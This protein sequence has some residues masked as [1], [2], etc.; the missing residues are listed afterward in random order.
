M[1]MQIKRK[2]I[3]VIYDLE[4]FRCCQ[5]LNRYSAGLELSGKFEPYKEKTHS[6]LNGD[7]YS[8]TRGLLMG[9]PYSS[10]GI[11]QRDSPEV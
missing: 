9:A 2:K 1:K 3:G 4:I 10:S 11:A 8:L 5:G 7:Y 6:F